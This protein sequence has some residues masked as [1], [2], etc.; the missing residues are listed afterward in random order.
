MSLKTMLYDV[1]SALLRGHYVQQ[2]AS[3]TIALGV[4]GTLY[5]YFDGV[6]ENLHNRISTLET[7]AFS[8]YL[9]AFIDLSQL[10]ICL[11]ALL[12]TAAF[13]ITWRF[14]YDLKPRSKV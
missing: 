5:S 8:D 10:D 11:T 2:F 12:G 1:G 13:C 9:L 14:T 4:I 7:L 6:L 3:I